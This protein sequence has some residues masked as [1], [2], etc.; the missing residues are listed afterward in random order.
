MAFVAR[1]IEEQFLL[2]IA[3]STKKAGLRRVS[4]PLPTNKWHKFSL[5]GDDWDDM[6]S[7]IG[8][9]ENILV[10][11]IRKFNVETRRDILQGYDHFSG[12]VMS[13]WLTALTPFSV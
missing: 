5:D 7:A 3:W 11:C 8:K 1:C 13:Q 12:E 10:H 2:T 4:R 6:I 9:S